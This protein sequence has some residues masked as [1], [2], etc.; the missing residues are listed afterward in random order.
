MI[1]SFSRFL[2]TPLVVL[3]AS[4]CARRLGPRWAGQL[5][6]APT[7]TGPFVILI[8]L[9]AGIGRGAAAAL[10]CVIGGL[11]V[12]SYCLLY[13]LLAQ[14]WRPL[15]SWVAAIGCSLL[16]GVLTLLWPSLWVWTALTLVITVGALMLWPATTK[17][18]TVAA[19]SR[20]ETP[21]RMLLTGVTVLVATLAT[22]ILGPL[23]GGLLSSLPVILGVMM[24]SV[25]R[26]S[27]AAAATELARG[28]LI[29]MP[30]TT[31]FLLLAGLSLP[32]LGLL[33]GFGVA[34]AGL[35]VT[36][37]AVRAAVAALRQSRGSL[38][39]RA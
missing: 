31:I 7:T 17:P 14:R 37:W 25:H 10:G 34:I 8:C 35:I 11:T 39:A 3:I 13:S 1:I 5:I 21:V 20:I 26:G 30:G 32:A 36:G 9:S 6:G 23:I 12:V 29:A 4:V 28:A 18:A 33:G 24:P 16:I 22:Q 2:L 38:I 27:G 19:P 15:H